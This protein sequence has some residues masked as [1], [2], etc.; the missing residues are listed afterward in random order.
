MKYSRHCQIIFVLVIFGEL[1]LY[2]SKSYQKTISTQKN[3]W[4][5]AYRKYTDMDGPQHG[6]IKWVTYSRTKNDNNNFLD[7]HHQF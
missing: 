4:K 2:A 1:R 3:V 5:S 6:T 7:I